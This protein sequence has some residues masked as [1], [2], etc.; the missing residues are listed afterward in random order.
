MRKFQTHLA[1]ASDLAVSMRRMTICLANCFLNRQEISYATKLLLQRAKAEKR[2][3]NISKLSSHVLDRR[4]HHIP[5]DSGTQKDSDIRRSGS[6]AAECNARN[7]HRRNRACNDTRWD[8]CS[9]LGADRSFA[10]TTA[11]RTDRLANLRTVTA[12]NFSLITKCQ[13]KFN[14]P[15]RHFKSPFS[16]HL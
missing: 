11:H 5:C 12:S 14:V 8:V 16:S 1:L 13:L 7:S 9:S 3:E 4:C 10:C 6:Q 2:N 15:G